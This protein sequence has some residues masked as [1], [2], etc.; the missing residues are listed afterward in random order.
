MAEGL[1]SS[2]LTSIE[3]VARQLDDSRSTRLSTKPID[4]EAYLRARED[5]IGRIKSTPSFRDDVIDEMF[6]R[7]GSAGHDLPWPTTHQKFRVLP[8]EVSIWAGFNG[9]GKSFVTGF[10]GLSL[11]H[12]GQKMCIASMEMKPRKTLKRMACQAIGTRFPTEAA[13]HQFLDA[14]TEKLYLYDQLG[15]VSPERI[16]GVI[17]YCAEKLGVTQFV[18]DSL[19]KVVAGEDD[20]NGQKAFVSRL[21]AAAKDLNVHVHL[22][23]HSRKREDESRRPGKQD[24]KGSGA[25]VDQVDNFISVF[26]LPAK[27]EPVEGEPSHAVFIDKARNQEWEGAVPLWFCEDSYQFSD[28]PRKQRV[29]YV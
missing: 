2:S 8:G 29:Q 28:S 27:K 26:K 3:A 11:M 24:S 19:M 5:D 23:H 20:Y 10:V 9:H 21:C 16:L 14:Y 13:V 18:V 22:V 7:G 25:I 6:G 4:F 15:D 17:Y 12:Q 1:L